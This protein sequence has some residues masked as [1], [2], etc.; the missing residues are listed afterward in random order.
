[1]ERLLRD[2]RYALRRIRSSPGFTVIAVLSIAMGIGANTS[3][4]SMVKFLLMPE[5]PYDDPAALVDI[6]PTQG[7]RIVFGTLSYP[8]LKAIVEGTGHVFSGV[9]AGTLAAVRENFEDHSQPRTALIVTGNYFQVLGN[10]MAAGRA[11]GPEDDVAPGAH[12][13]AVLGHRYWQQRFQGDPSA[14]GQGIRL[15]GRRYT[16]IGIAAP[17]APSLMPG[18]EP[19][20]W[21]P[22]MMMNAIKNSTF[23][24][25]EASGY[26]V[27]LAKARRRPDVSPAQAQ[28]ALDRVTEQIELLRPETDDDRRLKAVP[29]GDVGFHPF[30]DRFLYPAA[31][32][33]LAI[34]IVVLM[35][36]CLN[37]A[38]FLLARGADRRREIAVHLALGANRATLV[39]RLLTE[40]LLIGLLG[41]GLGCLMAYGS[42]RLFANIEL[43]TPVPVR[44]NPGLD[45]SALLYT[46]VVSLAAGAF[47]GLVPALQTTKARL[48]PDL[49]DEPRATIRSRRRLHSRDH[50]VI[51]QVAMSFV[52]FICS[53][54][55]LRSLWMAQQADPGFGCEPT[56]VVRLGVPAD[57]YPDERGRQFFRQVVDQTRALPGVRAA[58]M[59]DQLALSGSNFFTATVNIPQV[60]PPSGAVGHRVGVAVVDSGFF[61]AMGI[62][63]IFGRPFSEMEEKVV[64]VSQAM[65]NRFWP[66]RDPVGESVVDRQEVVHRVVGVAR[67][68]D[69]E[70]LGEAPKPFLY[71]PFASYQRTEM[72]L[73]AR[74]ASDPRAVASQVLDIARRIEPDV[75]VIESKTMEEH[76]SLMLLPFRVGGLLLGLFGAMSVLL[77]VIGLYGVVKYSAA[78]RTRE[79]CLRM[80]LGA[81]RNEVVALVMRGGLRLVA[82][83]VVAGIALSLAASMAL[84]RYLF[85]VRPFDPITYLVVAALMFALAAASAGLPAVRASRIDPAR[86]LREDA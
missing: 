16:I 54:L 23:D 30:V 3:N 7:G 47:F 19:D 61:E 86:V 1:M 10:R 59:V 46:L 39:R 64:I 73:I 31:I 69:T 11:L 49:K 40:S 77:A 36:A 81:Q 76:L 32:L 12:A 13:V 15:Q 71:V 74:T 68:I 37:L 34:P 53:G 63:M 33:L 9:A 6:Y 52:L 8:D 29:T 4:Y 70:R 38:S 42:M 24:Q 60:A 44:L 67:D 66:G 28:A 83:G 51:G 75:A 35:I 78:R 45:A 26:R 79:V 14:V 50:L 55:F 17:N 21:V 5:S 41:G 80:S 20:F 2:L 25:L 65:A 84:S 48:V 27:F 22:A 18:V 62:P 85:G 82:I 43:P 57:R 58:G 56:S 72:Y